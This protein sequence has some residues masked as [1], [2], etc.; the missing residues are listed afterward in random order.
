M[1]HNL[2]RCATSWESYPFDH[3]QQSV[4]QLLNQHFRIKFPVASEKCNKAYE[5]QLEAVGWVCCFNSY[6]A[7]RYLWFG[8]LE[9]HKAVPHE[10][11]PGLVPVF[12]STHSHT[13]VGHME[14]SP[15]NHTF[16]QLKIT[17]TNIH[18]N[19]TNNNIKMVPHLNFFI[20]M[21]LTS[22]PMMT[23]LSFLPPSAIL[24]LFNRP[25]FSS[26]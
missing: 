18:K 21:F 10:H 5:L 8:I 11:H 3:S 6:P 15:A 1:W 17:L 2:P 4:N 24:V 26:S 22:S 19:I 25:A 12:P 16:L 13:L 9:E 14:F 20:V 7:G 23:Y